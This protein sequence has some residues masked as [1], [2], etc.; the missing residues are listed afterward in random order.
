MLGP[1]PH[2][3]NWLITLGLG[4][5]SQELVHSG[6]SVIPKRFAYDLLFDASRHDCGL[7]GLPYKQPEIMMTARY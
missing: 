7:E 1:P 6:A 5:W 2:P 4:R 3:V